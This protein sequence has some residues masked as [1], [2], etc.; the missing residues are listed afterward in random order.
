[1]KKQV[2]KFAKITESILQ[3]SD[4][5]YILLKNITIKFPMRGK[6]YIKHAYPKGTEI[7][8]E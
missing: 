1:M 6:T 5:N 4:H 8:I 7:I 2:K 3:A